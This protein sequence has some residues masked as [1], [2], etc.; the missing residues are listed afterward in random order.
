MNSKVFAQRFN[1]ELNLLGFPDEVNDKIKAICKVF[2][3]N[4][5]TAN[6][7]IFGNT[8]PSID[9]LD[10]IASVLEVCPHW[11]SGKV[12]KRKTYLAKSN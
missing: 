3:I 11:L 7:L 2:D 8:L 6:G 10:K 1:R 4:R 9:L 5:H 12:D